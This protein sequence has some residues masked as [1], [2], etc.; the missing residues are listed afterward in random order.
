MQSTLIRAALI[1]AVA[2][3]LGSAAYITSAGPAQAAPT[4]AQKQAVQA[5]RGY[6]RMIAMNFGPLVAMAKGEAPYDKDK[7]AL[8]GGN[9]GSLAKVDLT[10]VFP[11]GTDNDAMFGETR[12]L[13]K[14]WANFDVAKKKDDAFEQAAAALAAA[15]PNGLDALRPTVGA[16][17]GTCKGCHDEY[18]AKDF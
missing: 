1:A 9:I 7:A 18:R 13:P 2:G 4:E 16:L 6:F 14:L 10:P 15:A 3:G 5:R 11:E 17:G 8:Y 12:T